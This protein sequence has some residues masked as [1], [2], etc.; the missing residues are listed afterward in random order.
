MRKSS[1][2]PVSRLLRDHKFDRILNFRKFQ[3][4]P[5]T[6]EFSSTHKYTLLDPE[7]FKVDSL[8][9]KTKIELEE[10]LSKDEANKHHNNDLSAMVHKLKLDVS[11]EDFKFDDVIKACLPDELMT[12]ENVNAKGY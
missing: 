3:F 9:D 2:L 11:Y 6:D 4:V 7:S 10:L 12:N 1:I 8:S 5:E